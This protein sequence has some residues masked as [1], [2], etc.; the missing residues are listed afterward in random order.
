MPKP[1]TPPD[2]PPPPIPTH[3]MTTIHM[4][5]DAYFKSIFSRPEIAADA[6]RRLL[7]PALAEAIDWDRLE[8]MPAEFIDDDLSAHRADL[9]YRVPL[10]GQTAYIFVLY[11]HQSSIDAMMPFRVLVYMVGIWKEW[12]RANP[13]AR[14]LPPVVPIVLYHGDRIWTAPLDFHALFATDPAVLDALAP[15]LP[16]FEV[17]LDDLAR[18]DDDTIERGTRRALAT[19]ALMMLKH[20]AHDPELMAVFTRLRRHLSAMLTEPGGLEA[21]RSTAYYALSNSNLESGFVERIIAANLDPVVQEVIVSTA[22]RLY[23]EGHDKG[24]EEGREEGRDREREAILLRGLRHKFGELPDSLRA[25]IANASQAEHD[26]W[27]LR[28][29]SAQSIADV[30]AE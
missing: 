5:H 2:T 12:R 25:R 20:A 3:P 19:V 27:L 23:D 29:F 10:R 4:S 18:T 9:V 24:R 28:A 22:Q 26:A 17:L 1:P 13:T 30:F 21:L 14:H 8:L 16:A 11:E 6:L 7:P 15:H